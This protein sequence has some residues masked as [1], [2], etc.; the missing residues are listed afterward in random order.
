MYMKQSALTLL[1]STGL[2]HFAACGSPAAPG[3]VAA[4]TAAGADALVEVEG[5]DV[6]GTDAQNSDAPGTDAVTPEVQDISALYDVDVPMPSGPFAC[7][8]HSCQPTQ[9]CQHAF[10]G[11]DFQ[12]YCDDGGDSDAGY[13]CPP[14][15]NSHCV[16]IPAS[17]QDSPCE[18][19]CNQ[20]EGNN[21]MGGCSQSGHYVEC[22]GI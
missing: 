13:L 15:D 17:C 8:A 11:N 4:D 12:V 19:L 16:T 21:A 9:Y 6:A 20:P 10:S 18:C 7:G 2:L 14:P 1:A 3:A 22:Q 5:G